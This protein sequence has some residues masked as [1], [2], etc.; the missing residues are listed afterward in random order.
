MRVKILFSALFLALATAGVF[1]ASGAQAA[2]LFCN[3]T[4]ALIEAAFGY[5]EE[6]IWVSEGWWQM[7]PGQCARVYNKSLGQRFYFY[8][9]HELAPIG[10]NGK[11]PLAWGGKYAFCAD[12]K[13]FRIDGDGDCEAKGYRT[14]GFQE[15]DVG[16][17]RDYT[18][19]FYSSPH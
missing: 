2:F 11:R 8:Y 10:A 7:Q 17:Q 9:A 6:G 18:L 14:Q 3:K 13:A 19:T 12:G 15:V 1:W 16:G 5:R 4:E